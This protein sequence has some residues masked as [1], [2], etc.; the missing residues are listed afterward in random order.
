MEKE[1]DLSKVHASEMVV[2]HP[3]KRIG[4]VTSEWNPEI[5]HAM[6]DACA[7]TL[8]EHGVQS[9]RIQFVSVPGSFELP[10][11]AQQI[12][13]SDGMDAVIC[14]GCVIQGETRH[15][16]FIAQA[17]AQGIM[18]VSLD[19]N[20]PVIFGVLTTQ[21]MEQAQARSGGI[22]GNKGVEAAYTCL[23]MLSI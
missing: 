18:R 23:K 3:G 11:A 14:I 2:C 17:V 19:N 10:F 21:T 22:H 6:R 9:N 13:Q 1:K 5:T 8:E 16:E 12:I 20:T 4:I 15:F 7:K